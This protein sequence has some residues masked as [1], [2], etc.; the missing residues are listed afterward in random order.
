MHTEMN[1]SITRF[2]LADD[3][4]LC[5]ECG[6]QMAEISRLNEGD[7]AYIWLRCGNDGCGGQWLQK[8]RCSELKECQVCEKVRSPKERGL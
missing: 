1:L 4:G 8:K 5:P 7:S 6:V 3:K 2:Q